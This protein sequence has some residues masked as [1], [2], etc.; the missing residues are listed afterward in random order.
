MKIGGKT[1]GGGAPVFV[2]AEAGVNHNGR[3]DRAIALAE[4]AAEA[5]ADAVKFQHF[6]PE[7]IVVPEAPQ[8]D[9][10]KIQAPGYKGQMDMLKSLALDL[11]AH[12]KIQARCRELGIIYL[13]TPYDE[14][15]M[16]ELAEIGVAGI[17][18]ASTDTTNLP[19]LRKLDALGL[20]V[21]LSTGMCSLDEV[22]KA[23][24]AMPSLWAVD[25]LA[26]LQCTSEYPSPVGDSNL[27]AISQLASAFNV[28][29]GFSDHTPGVGVSPWAVAA[30]ACIIEKHFTLDRSLPGPDHKA[31]LEPD[32]LRELVAM[33]RQV[34]AAM[35][36][37][38]KRVMASEERN[39]PLM[40]KR[41]V[42]CRDLPS[43]TVLEEVHLAAKRAS[44]GIPVIHWD[45]IV[46]RRLGQ[47]L[48]AETPLE[49]EHLAAQ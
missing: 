14:R 38:H 5:G 8:A 17:K 41:I 46:G 30:G 33:V 15:S 43:G 25:K 31:S 10:Q 26:L 28:L 13:C 44:R 36:D 37:G 2:I 7:L 47:P 35:G 18:V 1:L 22:G 29:V 3:P 19:L 32:E 34:E 16:R 48:R 20:P 39:K 40:Q 12:E 23:V 21:I 24:K 42:T 45:E 11:A 27:R 4:K 49:F 6:Y 9:Y